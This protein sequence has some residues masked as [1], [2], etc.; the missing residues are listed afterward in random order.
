MSNYLN[1]KV[2]LDPLWC[3]KRT[4]TCKMTFYTSLEV[5][6]CLVVLMYVG[7]LQTGKLILKTFFKIQ[8]YTLKI[9]ISKRWITTC[10][11]SKVVICYQ[12]PNLISI[13]IL[14]WFGA[15]SFMCLFWFASMMLTQRRTKWESSFSTTKWLKTIFKLMYWLILMIF[16]GFH[17]QT[18]V[19]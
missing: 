1:D 13:Y 7:V 3:T 18:P 10:Q 16:I 5:L 15:I 8:L 19:K 14:K 11:Q 2:Y 4:R 6:L 9:I 12:A 17:V